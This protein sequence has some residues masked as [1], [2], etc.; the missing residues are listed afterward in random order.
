MCVC[1]GG[2]G[3]GAFALPLGLDEVKEMEQVLHEN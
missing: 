1:G 2:G 3:G